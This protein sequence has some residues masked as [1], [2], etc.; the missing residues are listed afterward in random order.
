MKPDPLIWTRAED[1]PITWHGVSDQNVEDLL[2][3]AM[4]KEPRADAEGFLRELLAAGSMASA[5]VEQQAKAA[6]ISWRTLRRAADAIGVKRWKEG[7]ADGRWFWRLPDGQPI[8]VEKSPDDDAPNLST[9]LHTD[10]DKLDKFPGVKVSN[11]AESGQVHATTPIPT[12]GAGHVMEGVQL[13]HM[14]VLGVGQVPNGAADRLPADCLTPKLCGGK[15]GR[16]ARAPRC[17]VAS[18]AIGATT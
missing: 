8:C 5:D 11:D 15:L 9:P 3:G 14:D 10:V 4:S 13:V 1:G 6:G 17:R 2:Q 12:N 16:C 7:G 18:A